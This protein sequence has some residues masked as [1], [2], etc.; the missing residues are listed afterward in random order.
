M[1][2]MTDMDYTKVKQ[3][4]ASADVDHPKVKIE[5][6]NWNRNGISPLL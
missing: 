1:Q 2:E 4:I 5:E 3:D 6:P